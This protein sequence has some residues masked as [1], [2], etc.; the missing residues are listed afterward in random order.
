MIV[1]NAGLESTALDAQTDLNFAIAFNFVNPNHLMDMAA[2]GHVAAAYQLPR[3]I[4]FVVA[5][6][7]SFAI[8]PV[9]IA[10]GIVHTARTASQRE[11]SEHPGNQ[12]E[13]RSEKLRKGNGEW[14]MA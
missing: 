12:H 6:F 9:V 11:C 14:L 3:A 1:I 4:A 7:D 13:R 5:Q 2:F 10:G 8:D